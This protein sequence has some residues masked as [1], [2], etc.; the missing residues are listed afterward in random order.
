[1]Q[2]S[3]PGLSGRSAHRVPGEGDGRGL[4][5]DAEAVGGGEAAHGRTP[6]AAVGR[7]DGDRSGGL[8]AGG[9]GGASQTTLDQS[10][11]VEAQW[12]QQ[13]NT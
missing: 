10:P 2:R 11:T 3:R 8:G 12:P 13:L 1:M 5:G 6:T 7:G 4:P 9:E